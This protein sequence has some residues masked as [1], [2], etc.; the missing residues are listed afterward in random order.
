MEN[1]KK[2]K[3][4]HIL[5]IVAICLSSLSILFSS[6]SLGFSISKCNSCP[7]PMACNMGNGFANNY[8]VGFGNRTWG[9]GFQNM[10]N[11]DSTGR[12]RR[13]NPGSNDKF[14][15]N[16][17]TPFTSDATTKSEERGPVNK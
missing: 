17:K 15:E 9:R 13:N 12:Q 5:T 14:Q 4:W 10:W 3:V 16:R 6:F 8:G 1:E 11:D 2:C 7:A